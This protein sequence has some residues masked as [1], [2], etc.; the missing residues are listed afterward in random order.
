MG[1]LFFTHPLVGNTSA[2]FIGFAY[3]VLQ[4]QSLKQEK[5][6]SPLELRWEAGQTAG[7]HYL[8]KNTK[9]NQE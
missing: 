8:L 6:F 2:V 4:V 3:V 9:N 5:L 1:K 7:S